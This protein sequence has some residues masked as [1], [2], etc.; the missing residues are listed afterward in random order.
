MV[1]RHPESQA[2]GFL[3]SSSYSPQWIKDL[4][5]KKICKIQNTTVLSQVWR[6]HTLSDFQWFNSSQSHADSYILG[7]ELQ[8]IFE[9]WVKSVPQVI[10]NEVEA[11]YVDW[12]GFLKPP[13]HCLWHEDT[14]AI[15]QGETENQ[16][17]YFF[18]R[19]CKPWEMIQ[20]L[21]YY[22]VAGGF[23]CSLCSSLSTF[24]DFSSLH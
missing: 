10:D 6:S 1:P 4:S 19:Q 8:G 14:T 22:V 13:F 12:L 24:T 5:G 18:E 15:W 20:D 11:K 9:T 3:L 17:K 16:L 2:L 21:F 23:G 7:S